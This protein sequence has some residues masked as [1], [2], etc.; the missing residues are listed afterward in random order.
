MR[1]FEGK[2]ASSKNIKVTRGY[3]QTNSSETET[4]YC[5]YCSPLNFL[6][7]TLIHKRGSS[8]TFHYLFW[9]KNLKGKMYQ[10]KQNRTRNSLNITS[11][12][13]KN[14]QETD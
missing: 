14:R 13:K 11:E 12:K 4:P 3:Y 1:S 6:A 9:M 7:R 2:Y 8:N 5:L 10:M